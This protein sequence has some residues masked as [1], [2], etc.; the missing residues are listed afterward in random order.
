MGE[1]VGFKRPA[2]ESRLVWV[3]NCGCTTFRLFAD[4]H[5]ECA[6]CE[7]TANG[8]PEDWRERLPATPAEPLQVEPDGFAVKDIGDADVF[9]KRQ[10]K[11]AG[12]IAS[13]VILHDDA[14]I[15]SWQR[16]DADPDWIKTQ[17]D[18]AKTRLVR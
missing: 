10:A 14:L 18:H 6:G 4:G 1:V 9:L 8:E 2:D 7:T 15:S 16:S 13:V 3:C 12:R 5:A 17:L 11:D